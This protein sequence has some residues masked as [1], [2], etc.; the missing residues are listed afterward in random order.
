MSNQEAFT[1]EREVTPSDIYALRRTL[2]WARSAFARAK[3][4]QES[5][6]EEAGGG[7]S[8]AT[9]RAEAMA[10][11]ATARRDATRYHQQVKA[12]EAVL[13][14]LTDAQLALPFSVDKVDKESGDEEGGSIGDW[15]GD[16]RPQGDVRAPCGDEPKGSR[17]ASQPAAAAGVAG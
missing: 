9:E 5:R 17:A 3:D 12:L 10:R 15:A 11:V 13:G 2:A 4:R 7:F 6:E 8:D 16:G 14:E 1:I